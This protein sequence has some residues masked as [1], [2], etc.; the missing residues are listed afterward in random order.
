MGLVEVIGGN[1]FWYVRG[2]AAT[3]FGL[4]WEG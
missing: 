3:W 2:H 4:V 1:T